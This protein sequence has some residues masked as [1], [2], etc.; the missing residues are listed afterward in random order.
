MP[1]R[2]AGAKAAGAGEAGG[3]TPLARVVLATQNAGKAA[4]LERLLRR[5]A[6]RID[7][8]A[9]C[10][11][12]L[13][14][15]GHHSYT[16]NALAKARA[17]HAALGVPAIGDDSGLEVDALD[18]APGI[19]SSRFAGERA[20]DARNNAFLLS[21]LH[22]IAPERRTARFRCVL[23][24]AGAGGDDVV[25]E[26]V[27]EGVI[28]EAP[29]GSAGFGYDPLFLPAGG[30]RTFAELSEAE[31]D[32]VSHRGRAAAALREAIIRTRT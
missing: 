21:R 13:P 17:V 12:A 1:S 4:E 20:G 26:G 31:K 10:N 32:R 23:A 2:R 25:V 8:L 24:L 27:C 7:S 9:T 14:P 30:F 16:E 18:G 29:R 6:D 19:R 11:V 3:S 28:L 15:E 22:G 5:I